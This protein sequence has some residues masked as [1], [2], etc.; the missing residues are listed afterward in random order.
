[1]CEIPNTNAELK[2]CEGDFG[3][4]W[5]MINDQVRNQ[6]LQFQVIEHCLILT[7]MSNEIMSRL[8]YIK[9][10][11]YNASQPI[12]LD[13]KTETL[14]NGQKFRF[15]FDASFSKLRSKLEKKFPDID[16]NTL[17]KVSR[18]TITN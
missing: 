3:H 7:D 1:M 4:I 8:F 2:P 5:N 16:S 17:S 18:S 14:E 15:L 11:I 12:S 6:N 10:Q 13:A 9:N